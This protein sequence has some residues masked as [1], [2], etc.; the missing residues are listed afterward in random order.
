MGPPFFNRVNLPIGLVLLALTGIGPVI[1][2]RR[3]TRRNLKRNFALP[4][5]AGV[6]VVAALWALGAR[7]GY[8]LSTFG[9]STFVLTVIVVE[10]WKGTKARARIEGEG[11][12]PALV[13]LVGRNRRRWGGYIV[14]VGVVLIF[15]AFA[16]RAFEVEVRKS[17]NPGETVTVASPF[18]YAYTLTYEGISSSREANFDRWVALM[19]IQKD[20]EALGGHVHGAPFLS[21]QGD[22]DHRGGDP[23]DSG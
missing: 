22:D 8:A 17:M 11:F 12:F 9:I 20:G 7:G 1:A 23:I 15:T 4:V 2:W 3:A 21:Q 16:G 13:H 19:S 10:F 18:G 5:V 6:V 14:H